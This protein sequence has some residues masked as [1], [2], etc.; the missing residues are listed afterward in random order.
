MAESCLSVG[1]E[2]RA[3]CSLC[4]KL[5][6]RRNH[7]ATLGNNPPVAI[8]PLLQTFKVN[9]IAQNFYLTYRYYVYNNRI[10]LILVL[11]FPIFIQ[12]LNNLGDF[13]DQVISFHSLVSSWFEYD[14]V[15]K[16]KP[17]RHRSYNDTAIHCINSKH[18]V[19][20][21]FPRP[22][23]VFNGSFWHLQD[24]GE[25]IKHWSSDIWNL[26][27]KQCLKVLP[28]YKTLLEKQS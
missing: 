22:F 13:L 24:L 8:G 5:W 20:F 6:L 2:L 14:A 17:E 19:E 16:W 4:R 25:S 10:I 18:E 7:P 21:E 23:N 15:L 26:L 11:N 27:I 3:G 12:I 28:R 1:L 9:L